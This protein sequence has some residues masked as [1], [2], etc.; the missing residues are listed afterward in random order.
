MAKNP[1]T[2]KFEPPQT[3]NIG[4]S[5]MEQDEEQ[6]NEEKLNIT[7][8][9]PIDEEEE[10]YQPATA[11]AEFFDNEQPE[12]VQAE[13]L[14][15]SIAKKLFNLSKEQLDELELVL[16]EFYN[17]NFGPDAYEKGNI[18]EK[19]QS[20]RKRIRLMIQFL[21]DNNFY[22][23][24]NQSLGVLGFGRRLVK[25]AP[26]SNKKHKKVVKKVIYGRGMLEGQGVPLEQ[27]TMSYIPFGKYIIEYQPLISNN[28]LNVRYTSTGLKV[29]TFSNVKV[30]NDF[31]DIITDIQEK[32]Q[33]N[34]RAFNRL[35]GDEK[36]LMVSLLKSSGGH[37]ALNIPDNTLMSKHELIC[38][39]RFEELKQEIK[40]TRRH[41]KSF[42]DK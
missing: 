38:I 3:V 39:E 33:F 4:T 40:K 26:K 20:R 27:S 13:V 19:L 6:D 28:N 37:I 31:Q 21:I 34:E 14:K 11:F 42:I 15:E 10:E 8:A 23:L 36:T 29:K 12:I 2:V 32:Q 16:E 41:P 18:N 25:R 9:E 30:S 35:I 5:P 24:E 7:V 17:Q 1:D 22:S